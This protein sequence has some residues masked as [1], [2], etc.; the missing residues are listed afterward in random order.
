M[1]DRW[2]IPSS[3]EPS[4]FHLPEPGSH[5]KYWDRFPCRICFEALSDATSI[6][7]LQIYR[8][9]NKYHDYVS[10]CNHVAV[11]WLIAEP[12]LSQHGYR[13]MRRGDD[14]AYVGEGGD[15]LW[16][17]DHQPSKFAV[18]SDHPDNYTVPV[19]EIFYFNP[20][21]ATVGVDPEP[22]DG[23]LFVVMNRFDKVTPEDVPSWQSGYP[24]VHTFED[25][26]QF[27][28]QMAQV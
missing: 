8:W 6:H 9:W 1:T 19:R 18:R 25:L 24:F 17:G 20:D 5:C 10:E 2:E 27:F 3:L 26:Y 16:L 4:P 21:F 15:K 23:R 11:P 13:L 7:P 14:P 12:F 22:T 28:L